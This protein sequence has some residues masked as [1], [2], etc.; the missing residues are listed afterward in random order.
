MNDCGLVVKYYPPNLSNRSLR[1]AIAYLRHSYSFAPRFSSW[2]L[3]ALVDE[4]ERRLRGRLDGEPRETELL[5]IR[6]E[7][8]SN[9]ALAQALTLSN[10]LSYAVRDEGFGEL[11]D[12]VVKVLT[13]CV[14][15]RL[16]HDQERINASY[17]TTQNHC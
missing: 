5:T 11:L 13:A 16:E 12:S 3:E 9:A 7:T 17:T 6:P 10:T 8:W 14:T 2:L 1:V 4:Q 15:A